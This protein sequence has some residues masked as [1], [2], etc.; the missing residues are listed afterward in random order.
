LQPET[1]WWFVNAHKPTWIKRNKKEV[2]PTVQHAPD[3]R[4]IVEVAEAILA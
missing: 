1:Q 3:S 2:M 4:R